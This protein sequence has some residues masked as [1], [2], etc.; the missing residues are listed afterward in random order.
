MAMDD[1][2]SGSSSD[3]SLNGK[4]KMNGAEVAVKYET[5]VKKKARSWIRQ[6][7]VI[8][9]AA[10]DM[11]VMTWT[12]EEP[13]STGRRLSCPECQ[14]KFDEATSLKRHVRTHLG[15]S[16]NICHVCRKGFPDASKLKRHQISLKHFPAPSSSMSDGSDPATSKDFD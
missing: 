2:I 3:E 8:K 7:K 5:P 4:R 13:L 12:T 15:K 14:K 6:W 16:K 1:A 10:G 11:K 9:T